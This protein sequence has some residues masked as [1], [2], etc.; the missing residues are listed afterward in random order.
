MPAKTTAQCKIVAQLRW[1]LP[2]I[3]TKP[4]SLCKFSPLSKV[5]LQSSLPSFISVN[6]NKFPFKDV[7]V[8]TLVVDACVGTV[9]EKKIF[10]QANI[11]SIDEYLK[12]GIPQRSIVLLSTR[13]D[14]RNLNISEA[15]MSLGT[16][17]PAHL[18][19]K[20][21]I[22][23]L[24]FRGNFKPSWAKLFTSPAGQGLGQIEKFIPLQME[25]LWLHQSEL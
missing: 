3:L 11:K 23:F 8:F 5:E 24:G 14:I 15:L 20:G 25:E 17:K 16:A 1:H 18:Q 2:V 13:G 7:G 4:T 9:T 22:A 10:L 19:N 6:G 21:S 12:T